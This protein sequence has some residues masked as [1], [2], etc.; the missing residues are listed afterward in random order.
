MLI[1]VCQPLELQRFLI[2]FLHGR[3]TDDVLP[4]KP[5]YPNAGSITG[6]NPIFDLIL[7]LLCQSP[8]MS[9]LYYGSR[10]TVIMSSNHLIFFQIQI[11]LSFKSIFGLKADLNLLRKELSLKS[12]LV[13]CTVRNF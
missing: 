1:A 7:R 12:Y 10:E 2:K 4:S 9:A 11:N 13:T 5:S 8:F 3:E 6:V